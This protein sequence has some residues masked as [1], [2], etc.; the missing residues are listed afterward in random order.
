MMLECSTLLCEWA[1]T[2]SYGK[3]RRGTLSESVLSLGGTGERVSRAHNFT[4][5]LQVSSVN[6][7][8]RILGIAVGVSVPGATCWCSRRRCKLPRLAGRDGPRPLQSMPLLPST[9]AA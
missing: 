8:F 5:A 3:P 6:F 7:A 9:C 1:V 4:R 2:E